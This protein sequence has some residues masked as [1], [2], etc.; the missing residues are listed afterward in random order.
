MDHRLSNGIITVDVADI[1]AYSGTRFDWTGFITQV[2]LEKG[3]HTF[4]VPESLKSGEGTGGIGICNEFGISR[5]IGFEEAPIGGWFPKLGVGLLQKQDSQEYN[6]FRSYPLTPFETEVVVKEDSLTYTIHPMEINGYAARLTKTISI[7]EDQLKIA[8]ELHN[9]GELP[10]ETDEYVHN[11]IGIDGLNIGEDFEF[12]LPGELIIEEPES[13]YTR[14]LLVASGNTL[15]WNDEPDRPFY[16][17]LRGWDVA[18][19]QYSW[20]LVHKPSGTGM[21]ESGDFPIAKMALW[22]ER[23]VVSSEVF[24]NIS[25][26]PR[27]SKAWS[28]TYQFFTS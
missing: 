12:R 13:A 9:T 16:C 3:K 28:R 26:L 23:H 8:Y 5:A 10:I 27:Q 19:P 2:T 18:D 14:D 6:F 24:V 22:G 15:H 4:C 21:R 25:L 7:K 11:F 1:G 20:E 17:K